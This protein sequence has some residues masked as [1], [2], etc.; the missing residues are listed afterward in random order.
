MPAPASPDPSSVQEREY[1][2][3]Y[4]YIPAV[5]GGQIAYSVA[6]DWAADYL[7]GIELVRKTLE[8][9]G[10]KRMCDVG[11]GDGRLINELSAKAPDVQFRGIDV[12]AR[13]LA[14]A[15][16]FRTRD[17]VQFREHD[18]TASI[19]A[20]LGNQDLVTLIEVLEHVPPEHAVAFL[21][22]A[23]ELVRP[24][25][26]FL[27]TVPHANVP[28][29]AKHYRHFTGESLLAVLR[30]ALGDEPPIDIRFMDKVE[31]GVRWLAAKLAKNR[32]FSIEPLFQW[33]LR[34]RLGVAF[35]PEAVGSR[36]VATVTKTAA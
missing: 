13:A 36:V 1:R 4:H 23:Y 34:R 18:L 28:V 16:L 24:G 30:S 6:M 27:V 2:F 10:A 9:L 12:S 14:L 29:H 11:C 5:E 21:R 26:T 22:R 7:N 15:N 17:N 3:P 35:V 8:R 32:Y 33:R 19:A 20:D 25:G 31:L